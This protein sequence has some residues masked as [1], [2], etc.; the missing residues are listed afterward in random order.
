MTNP[1]EA[2][3]LLFAVFFAVALWVIWAVAVWLQNAQ[4]VLDEGDRLA[5]E[6]DAAPLVYD[7]P[8]PGCGAVV[9]STKGLTPAEVEAFRAYF[10]TRPAVDVSL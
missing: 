1:H 7:I 6:R 10:N 2:L 4:A 3:P 9:H 5:A 8:M